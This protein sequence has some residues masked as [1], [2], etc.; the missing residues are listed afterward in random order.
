MKSENKHKTLID[1][2]A[3]PK[4]GTGTLYERAVNYIS[5]N[6]GKVNLESPI[7]KVLLNE[8]GNEVTGVELINGTIKETKNVVLLA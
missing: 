1:Q 4:N 6:G 3:Y 7:K 2:F 5:K 8:L